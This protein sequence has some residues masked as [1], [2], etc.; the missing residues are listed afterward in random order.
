MKTTTNLKKFIVATMAIASL[1]SVPSIIYATPLELDYD[2]STIEI[3]IQAPEDFEL[4]E[5]IVYYENGIKT[6]ISIFV[7]SNEI[8]SGSMSLPGIWVNVR[9]TFT[10]GIYIP[11]ST[12]YSRIVSG[13]THSG[14]LNLFR[15]DAS[16]GVINA[17]YD[18]FIHPTNGIFSAEIE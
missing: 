2:P 5:T 3:S 12:S 1:G 13:I 7:N 4:F 18:G 11:S 14:R 8:N 10:S 6:E 15:I 9:K 17:L 16:R